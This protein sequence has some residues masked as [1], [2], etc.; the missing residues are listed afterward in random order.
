[1]T[2]SCQRSNIIKMMF[3]TRELSLGIEPRLQLTWFAVPR[4]WSNGFILMLFRSVSGFCPDKYPTD[5]NRH[6]QLVAEATHDDFY[7]ERPE[8]GIY[9]Y[10]FILLRTF[11]WRRWGSNSTL[12]SRV[13]SEENV[14]RRC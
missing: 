1:M 3:V 7:E 2:M 12:F 6:G 13:R 10:T 5:L 9:Y 11:S 4:F 8:E 14:T